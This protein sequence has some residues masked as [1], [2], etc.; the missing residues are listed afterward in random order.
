MASTLLSAHILKRSYYNSS[1]KRRRRSPNY[2]PA[3][4][5]QCLGQFDRSPSEIHVKIW[6]PFGSN[7]VL[8]VTLGRVM[9]MAL[10]FK[11]LIIEWVVV[12]GFNEPLDD[13]EDLWV[14]SRYKVLQRVRDHMHS[15]MLHFFSPAL[16]ELAV[17]SL[18]T[19]INSY[20]TL[21]SDPCKRCGKLLQKSMPPTWRDFRSLEPFHDE[22]RH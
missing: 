13:V 4:V 8:H 5:D 2:S 9:K 21:F 1:S 12:K 22:C 6:R 11:G 15:A 10:I 20:L 19:W 7:A 3:S 18:M 16:P 14:E 17:R